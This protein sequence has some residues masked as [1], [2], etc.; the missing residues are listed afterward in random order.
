MHVPDALLDFKTAATMGA[1]S[2]AGLSVAL[3]QA[4][5][6]LPPR[7][8][9]LMGLAAAFVFAAQMINFP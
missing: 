8:V 5:K 1:L 4:R 6:H 2:G 3:R 9:P 7:R